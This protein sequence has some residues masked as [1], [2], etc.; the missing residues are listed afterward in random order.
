MTKY[1]Y[2]FVLLFLSLNVLHTAK[3]KLLHPGLEKNGESAKS[4]TDRYREK[5]FINLTT[6]ASDDDC[7]EAWKYGAS[8]VEQLGHFYSVV[9]EPRCTEALHRLEEECGIPEDNAEYSMEQL[10]YICARNNFGRVCYTLVL[11]ESSSEMSQVYA[12]CWEERDSHQCREDCRKA[13]GM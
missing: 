11:D 13:I 7:Y 8:N 5:Y 2:C 12:Q 6:Q 1:S 4:C 3:G 10:K 9:C